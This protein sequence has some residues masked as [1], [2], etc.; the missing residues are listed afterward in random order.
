MDQTLNSLV[1]LNAPDGSFCLRTRIGITPVAAFSINLKING[2]SFCGT[3]TLDSAGHP[4]QN[5]CP[6]T[7]IGICCEPP[8]IV[9]E[10]SSLS[11]IDSENTA[12]QGIITALIPAPNG[13]GNQ[14]LTLFVDCLSSQKSCI[15]LYSGMNKDIRSLY[16]ALFSINTTK[17]FLNTSFGVGDA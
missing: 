6:F 1:F 8:Q 7:Q 4:Q 13:T 12:M 11:T 14:Y 16:N 9:I 15:L 3:Y 5:N 10:K 17:N 2:S